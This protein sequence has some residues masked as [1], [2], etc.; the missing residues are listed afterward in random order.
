LHQASAVLLRPLAGQAQQQLDR[1]GAG[2]GFGK[3]ERLGVAVHRVVVGHQGVDGAV[4]QARAQRVAVALLAHRRLQAQAAV[5]KANVHIGQVQ[6]VHAHIA[7]HRQALG[8][9]LAHQGQAGRAADAAQVHARTGAA[10]RLALHRAHEFKQVCS[11]MVSA[12]A[13]MPD[14]PSAWPAGPLAATPLPSQKSCG[15][16]HTV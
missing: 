12:A 13:G 9:G 4:G 14:K 1:G 5:V 15:R 11:A 3:G 16:S 2:L 8:L 6:V 10:R 7:G